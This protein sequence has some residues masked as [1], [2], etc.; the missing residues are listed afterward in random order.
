MRRATSRHAVCF[1]ARSRSV[2]SSSTITY[3]MRC[4]VGHV[5]RRRIERRHRHRDVQADARRD[6]LH[7]AGGA[8][9]CDRLCAACAPDRPR[10]RENSSCSFCRG[11]ELCASRRSSRRTA[12]LVCMMCRDGVQRE[13][14][15]RDALQNRL[16]MP[17]T[18]LQLRV[19]V[20]QFGREASMLARLDSRSAAM[21]LNES[22]SC[23]ISLPAC[24]STRYRGGRGKSP[25]S[26]LPAPPADAS[27]SSTD[28]APATWRRTARR[29]SAA[30][31]SP[32]KSGA[33]A[34]A[35]G[36]GPGTVAG[37]FQCHAERRIV[38]GQRHGDEDLPFSAR[39]GPGPGHRSAP[40]DRRSLLC[41]WGPHSAW[42]LFGAAAAT[43]PGD[44]KLASA[45]SSSAAKAKPPCSVTSLRRN[46]SSTKLKFPVWND[47][48]ASGE[49]RC[50]AASSRALSARIRSAGKR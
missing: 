36:A 46:S 40:A 5:L 9:P 2:M 10:R 23:P 26:L 6:D 4:A 1:W 3:P 17:V 41:A 39:H 44:G 21:R 31:A 45:R 16:D 24:T 48:C 20:G 37:C 35:A 11:G 28:T 30:A 47:F 25:A 42:K 22:T 12:A 7:L 33:T 14:A 38:R 18:L 15:R 8:C 13:H 43:P 49:A 29:P 19:H 34:A 27:P 32:G 50:A